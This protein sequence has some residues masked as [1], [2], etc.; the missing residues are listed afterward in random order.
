MI[1]KIG[2]ADAIAG[3][4]ARRSENS[5]GVT[6][7]WIK[8]YL[9]DETLLDELLRQ[10]CGDD[11]FRGTKKSGGKLIRVILEEYDDLEETPPQYE[12]QK[13]ALKPSQISALICKDVDFPD[14]CGKYLADILKLMTEEKLINFKDDDE[15]NSAKVVRYACSIESRSELDTNEGAR[16]TFHAMIKDPFNAYKNQN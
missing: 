11:D 3:A 1:N 5:Q 14:F 12:E 10:F 8:L 13:A 16:N 7:A 4:W 2:E 6:D 9:P 15:I